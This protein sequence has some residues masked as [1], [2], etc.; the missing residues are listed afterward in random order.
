M[1]FYN[2]SL[3]LPFSKKNIKFRELNTY[4]QLALAKA[5]M[6]ID[7]KTE[8]GFFEY[9]EFINEILKNCVKNYNDLLNL[10]VIEYTM[11]VTKL[12]SIS[13]GNTIQ[14][15]L[16]NK[17]DES[18]SKQKLNLNLNFFL[19][20][21]YDK[22][23]ILFENENNLILDKQI[24]IKLKW[25]NIKNIHLFLKTNNSLYESFFEFVDRIE[26]DSIKIDF[27]N[28]TIEQK[29]ELIEKLSISTKQKI[30]Q[31]I[32]EIIQALLDTNFTGIEYFKDY[33]F[34]I[35]GMFFVSFLRLFLSNDIKSI[36][37]EIYYL[38][39]NGLDADYINNISPSERKIYLS[40]ITES[41]SKS[42]EDGW[43]EAVSSNRS[44]ED[45]AVEF[46]QGAK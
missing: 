1:N 37:S 4:E 26:I 39:N 35:Y 32:M 10:D 13:I 7:N 40:I 21:L 46:N 20:T 25:P 22:T 27:L 31:K 11:F 17:Q 6:T 38:C 15:L 41:K 8:N 24:T 42:S 44:L 18:I 3:D 43:S 30:E 23:N 19:K 16:E 45:L 5:N 9:F 33:K 36:Y 12:R 28:F 14:F 29:K 2:H 34:N